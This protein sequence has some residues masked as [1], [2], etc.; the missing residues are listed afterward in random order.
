MYHNDRMYFKPRPNVLIFN[1][2]MGILSLIL[3]IFL[4][5]SLITVNMDNSVRVPLIVMGIGSLLYGC[6]LLSFLWKLQLIV[7]KQGILYKEPFH[8]L[9]CKWDHFKGAACSEKTFLLQL[10]ETIKPRR[11]L[12][13]GMH[14][15]GEYIPIHFFVKNWQE[16]TNWQHNRLLKT[17]AI[18]LPGLDKE[19]IKD[20]N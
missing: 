9:F 12:I 18:Y 17:I 20:G 2:I 7:S 14:F 4:F 6:Y 3:A 10:D 5:W 16:Q 1:A 19:V 11:K 13:K 8:T 15:K